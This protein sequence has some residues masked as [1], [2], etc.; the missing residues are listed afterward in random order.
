[1]NKVFLIGNNVRDIELRYTSTNKPVV[2]FAL[3]VNRDY[4]NADGEYEC[5]FI[6][7][8]LYGKIAETVNAYVHKGD[9]LA[10][11]GRIQTRNYEDKD[12]NKRIATEVITDKVEFLST[13]RREEK[14]EEEKEEVV[15]Q[16]PFS[17][18]NNSVRVD[19]VSIDDNFLD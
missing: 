14:I 1:M 8:V 9:K 11:E 17:D 10:V 2:Q 18:F 19:Q 13:K 4:K 5:D 16:D 6:N 12:G 7:C 15:N 3:A